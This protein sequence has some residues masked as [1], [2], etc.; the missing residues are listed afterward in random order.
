[1]TA[2]PFTS[3]L[4]FR[5][6][7]AGVRPEALA[8]VVISALYFGVPP[9]MVAAGAA[10]APADWLIVIDAGDISNACTVVP[11][12]TEQLIVDN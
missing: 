2:V 5:G 12:D 4:I 7:R 1:V 9:I 6:V 8:D 10:V 11:P 3:A